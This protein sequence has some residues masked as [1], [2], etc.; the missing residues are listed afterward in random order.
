M[1]AS[2]PRTFWIEV[3]ACLLDGRP[4]A[5]SERLPARR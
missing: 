3:Q 5:R 2:W 1:L 4:I